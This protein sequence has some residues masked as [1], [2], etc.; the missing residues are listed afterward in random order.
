MTQRFCGWVYALAGILVILQV[1]TLILFFSTQAAWQNIHTGEGPADGCWAEF[2]PEAPVR[3]TT[4]RSSQ[5]P[6]AKVKRTY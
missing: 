2:G 3:P 4:T 6:P 5:Y 1:V